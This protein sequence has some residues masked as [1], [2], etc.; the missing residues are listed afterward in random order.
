[1]CSG[2]EIGQEHLW[3]GASGGAGKQIF[4]G[5]DNSLSSLAAGGMPTHPV[6]NHEQVAIA[7][8]GVEYANTVL[9]LGSPADVRCVVKLPGH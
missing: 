5:L 1:M 8:R 7:T 2:E 6:G 9:L 3:I 4:R